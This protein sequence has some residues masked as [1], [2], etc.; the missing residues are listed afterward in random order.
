MNENISIV[1][2]EGEWFWG[3]SIHLIAGD[4]MALVKLVIDNRCRTQGEIYDLNTH[5]SRRQQGYASRLIQE[6]EKE[7]T[8]RGCRRM[9][10]WVEKDSYQEA[11]YRRLGYD[12]EEFMTPPDKDT[13]WLKKFLKEKEI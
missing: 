7:A 13:I 6:A 5:P 8:L 4:G 3:T 2:I 11:W 1:K 10:L 9:V 12:N